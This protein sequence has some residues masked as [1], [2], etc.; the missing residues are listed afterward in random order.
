[1]T[2]E[3]CKALGL[4]VHERNITKAELLEADG[5]FLSLSSFGIVQGISLDGKPLKQSSLTERLHAAYLAAVRREL[6]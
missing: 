3:L 5:L 6:G 1:V 4:D 2:F